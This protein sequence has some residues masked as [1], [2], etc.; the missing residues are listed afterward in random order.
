MLFRIWFNSFN[1]N[2]I[3]FEYEWTIIVIHACSLFN[4]G[5]WDLF[6]GVSNSGCKCH[7]QQFHSFHRWNEADIILFT[8]VLQYYYYYPPIFFVQFSFLLSLGWSITECS[9]LVD[10]NKKWSIFSFPLLCISVIFFHTLFICCRLLCPEILCE[11]LFYDNN[12]SKS[13]KMSAFFSGDFILCIACT[14]CISKSIL[15]YSI[16]NEK[17]IPE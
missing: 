13:E 5:Y 12:A 4:N 3:R 17:L 11:D 1:F 16:H 7:C 9:L 2:A 10:S 15:F 8:K 14:L 6:S